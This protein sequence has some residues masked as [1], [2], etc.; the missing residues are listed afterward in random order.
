M[1]T[2]LIPFP[3]IPNGEEGYWVLRYIHDREVRSPFLG[4]K[5]AIWDFLGV[6][7][8]LVDLFWEER[9]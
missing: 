3:L 6:R 5:L 9:F 4:L 8:F 1:Q 2:F 7:N